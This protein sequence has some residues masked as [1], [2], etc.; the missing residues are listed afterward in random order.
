MLGTIIFLSTQYNSKLVNSLFWFDDDLTNDN[1][2]ISPQNCSPVL[3]T[4]NLEFTNFR[5]MFFSCIKNHDEIF[6]Q[7]VIYN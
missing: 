5:G 2:L 4:S 7:S 6:L 1:E 3:K